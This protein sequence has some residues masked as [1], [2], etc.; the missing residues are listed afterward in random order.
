MP[1]FDTASAIVR[2]VLHSRPIQEADKGHIHHRLLGRGF[3]QTQTVLIIYVWCA[4]LAVGG[5][6]VSWAGGPFKVVA[7][8]ALFVVTG[9]MAYWLGPV[10]G[11]A[12]SRGHRC[13]AKAEKAD[14]VGRRNKPECRLLPSERSCTMTLLVSREAGSDPEGSGDEGKERGPQ[15]PCS[16]ERS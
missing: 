15:E 16:C 13:D 3:D 6:T 1:I 7:F 10:R 9:F 8:V 12:A 14:A 2:R 4:A 5:Y 11:R